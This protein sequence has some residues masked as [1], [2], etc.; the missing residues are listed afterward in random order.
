MTLRRTCPPNCE[1]TLVSQRWNRFILFY[2]TQILLLLFPLF[3]CWDISDDI[4]FSDTLSGIADQEALIVHSV[5]SIKAVLLL[6]V[7]L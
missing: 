4:I 6:S 7:F 5:L 2:I 1:S 3:F